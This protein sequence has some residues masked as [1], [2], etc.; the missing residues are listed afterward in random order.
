M[1]PNESSVSHILLGLPL[2]NDTQEYPSGGLVGA[3]IAILSLLV[4]C[5]WLPVQFPLTELEQTE[6]DALRLQHLELDYRAYLAVA[7]ED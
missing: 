5:R 6:L 1:G 3:A 4:V 7:L 2:R